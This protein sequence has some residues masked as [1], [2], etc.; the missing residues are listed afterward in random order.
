MPVSFDII[1]LG[2]IEFNTRKITMA[3]CANW[4]RF[5]QPSVNSFVECRPLRGARPGLIARECATL[6]RLEGRNGPFGEGN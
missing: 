4:D 2:L 3:R 6:L 1:A 5:D